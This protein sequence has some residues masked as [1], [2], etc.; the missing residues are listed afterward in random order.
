MKVLAESNGGKSEARWVLCCD[1]GKERIEY[2]GACEQGDGREQ[3]QGGFRNRTGAI[4]EALREQHRRAREQGLSGL[5]VV[6]EASGGYEKPLLRLA[7]RQGHSTAWVNGEWV[8]KVKVVESNDSGKSD[9]KDPRVMQLL[10]GLGK[11]QEV[12]AGGDVYEELQVL[13]RLYEAQDRRGIELR[14]ELHKALWQLFPDFPMKPDFLYSRAG[15]VLIKLLG[16][17]PYRIAGL[18]LERFDHWLRKGGSRLR[19][20]TS[21]RIW[22]AARCSAR[23]ELGEAIIGHLVSHLGRLYRCWEQNEAY[24]Q[25]LRAALEE[26][27]EGTEEYERLSQLP[28]LKAYQL[29]RLLGEVGPLK[30]FRHWRQLARYCGLNLRE[31]RSGSYRGQVKISKKGCRLARRVLYQ[32]VFAAWITRGGLYEQSYR[33]LQA[34]LANGMKAIVALMRR[35][36]K[37]MHGMMKT[38]QAFDPRRI[39]RCASQY[40]QPLAA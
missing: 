2:C 14:N 16:A 18:S 31:R 11:R 15:G 5:L 10:V 39:E 36:L 37:M 25:Q 19:K 20:V 38:E 34:Q 26:A 33:R 40:P 29:G 22:E 3:E 21:R 23:H 7:R 4:E 28:R 17:N 12:R 6:C 9:E 24:R 13:S 32:V 35:A 27:V 8:S 30:R 1:V